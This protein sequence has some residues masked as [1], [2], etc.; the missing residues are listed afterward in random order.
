[1]I[2]RNYSMIAITLRKLIFQGIDFHEWSKCK[3]FARQELVFAK[4][5]KISETHEN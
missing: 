2:I 1:M 4:S 5:F 3:Y